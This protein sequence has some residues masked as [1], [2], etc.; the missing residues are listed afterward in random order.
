MADPKTSK[1]AG[2]RP[3]DGGGAGAFDRNRVP[4]YRGPS[5]EDDAAAMSQRFD[6]APAI[7]R[8]GAMSAGSRRAP[9]A[10][11][12]SERICKSIRY[13]DDYDVGLS[14][15]NPLA[16]VPRPPLLVRGKP[17]SIDDVFP[18]QALAD[19][20]AGTH[21]R[22]D[23]RDAFLER[24]A[25]GLVERGNVMAPAAEPPPKIALAEL[26][27]GSANVELYKR[28]IVEERDSAA[29]RSAVVLASVRTFRE[30]I[31]RIEWTQPKHLIIGGP[32]GSGKTFAA[33]TI[34]QALDRYAHVVNE[35]T[36]ALYVP[37]GT[38]LE[39]K[40][41]KARSR[42]VPFIVSVDGGDARATSQ[43]RKLVLQVALVL[44]YAGISDL[45]AKTKALDF[46]DAIKA[47][48]F[49]KSSWVHVVEPRTFTDITSESFA[50]VAVKPSRVIFCLV[51]TPDDVIR[52]Q[53]ADRAWFTGKNRKK[54]V[55]ENLDLNALDIG[56]E[57]KEYD[58]T[59]LSYGRT[60]SRHAHVKYMDAAVAN[61]RT[62]ISVV[63]E[64]RAKIVRTG[65]GETVEYERPN[66]QIHYGPFE[67]QRGFFRRKGEFAELPS[68]VRRLLAGASS[69][70]RPALNGGAELPR[71]PTAVV[72]V[73]EQQVI[74][75]H[76]FAPHVPV[77]RT[78]PEPTARRSVVADVL[79]P[80]N[81]DVRKVPFPPGETSVQTK[82]HE[83]WERAK[84]AVEVDANL[85]HVPIE[86][87]GYCL[88]TAVAT[89]LGK[90]TRALIDDL[91]AAARRL[92][93]E[94]LLRWCRELRSAGGLGRGAEGIDP[95]E[96]QDVLVA[97]GVALEIVNLEASPPQIVSVAARPDASSAAVR[98]LFRSKHYDL[99]L[100]RGAAASL[101]LPDDGSVYVAKGFRDASEL[102]RDP[103]TM[104]PLRALP[105]LLAND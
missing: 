94:P 69:G 10:E 40:G 61:G 3:S 77:E 17:V 31:E 8:R 96:I 73:A 23:A 39:L 21:Q 102:G 104:A 93:A 58:D 88:L 41:A 65:G 15:S 26:L 28:A 19:L 47:A 89:H 52:H 14:P 48:A 100:P 20:H 13:I 78:S 5:K 62:P 4:L 99:L 16:F 53:G 25:T 90:S 84:R 54:P 91:D 56:C 51:N 33:K 87:T 101:D 95:L 32:S 9:V 46:K 66:L 105:A 83:E 67:S 44:G 29:F 35:V 98:L 18:P 85:V 71:D 57:S 38:A 60:R 30:E 63:L 2:M 49:H 55:A 6:S 75:A 12:L 82:I 7:V 1:N 70:L 103:T 22:T 59:Y 79:A 45:H 24:F 37:G 72:H 43:I 81:P 68:A 92:G 76:G 86:A 74:V 80:K 36:D 42:R 34:L 11:V 97:A 64:N 50:S 27:G